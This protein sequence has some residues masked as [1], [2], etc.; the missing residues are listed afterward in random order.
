[1]PRTSSTK[2]ATA[3]RL[4]AVRVR[5]LAGVSEA[6]QLLEHAELIYESRRT[7]DI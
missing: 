6:V 5:D 1:M 7:E 4:F 2:S 3:R